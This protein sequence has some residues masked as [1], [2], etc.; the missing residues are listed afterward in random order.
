MA[1]M[2]AKNIVRFLLFLLMP[3]LCFAE[4]SVNHLFGVWQHATFVQTADGEVVRKFDSTDGSTLEYRPN[5]T[6]RLNSPTNKSSG[7]YRWMS[8]G[9]LESTIT[10]SDSPTQ[11]GYTSIK[12]VTVNDQTL[13][14]VAEYD[15]EGMKVMKARADGTRP[16]SMKVTST[17]RKITANK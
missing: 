8:N 11:I 9:I 12:K 14:L 7:T 6:W 2:Q 10:S 16:K 5:G 3:L 1:N 17:F 4:P 13:V 15:E